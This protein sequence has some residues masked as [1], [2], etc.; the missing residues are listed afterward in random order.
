M[1]YAVA[2]KP[3]KA[4]KSTKK[5]RAASKAQR[6]KDIKNAIRWNLPQLENDTMTLEN[7]SRT[8]VIRVLRLNQIHP[9][10]DPDGDHTM[11][12]LSPITGKY[13]RVNGVKCFHRDDL[14]KALKAYAEVA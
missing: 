11:Q 9:V 14:I 5:S 1:T 13:H 7:V 4:K 2:Y 10:T 8:Y 3:I 12:S 6:T